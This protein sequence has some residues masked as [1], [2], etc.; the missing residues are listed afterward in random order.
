MV[1]ISKCDLFLIPS[2]FLSFVSDPQQLP[3]AD[4]HNF[5]NTAHTSN[6]RHQTTLSSKFVNILPLKSSHG[7]E[8]CLFCCCGE[9]TEMPFQW[10]VAGV[11]K[12]ASLA[13][14]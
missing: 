11:A 1:L 3:T 14:D 7:A 10:G 5:C 9:M 13:L 4:P 6:L 8:L 12:V 2:S